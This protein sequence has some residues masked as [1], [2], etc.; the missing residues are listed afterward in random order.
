[1]CK[2]KIF[3]YRYLIQNIFIFFND[4]NT[5]RYLLEGTRGKIEKKNLQFAD[6]IGREKTIKKM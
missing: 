2:K 3:Q 1:M 5:D 4:N 6:A